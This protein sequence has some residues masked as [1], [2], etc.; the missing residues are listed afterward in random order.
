MP[1]EKI[2]SEIVK[3][4]A[5]R[6]KESQKR[7]QDVIDRW[8]K[9]E[10]VI[11]P[12]ILGATKFP[13]VPSVLQ[14]TTEGFDRLGELQ[15]QNKEDQ[16]FANTLSLE[17]INKYTPKF[18]PIAD[19]YGPKSSIFSERELADMSNQSE[20]EYRN[21]VGQFTNIFKSLEKPS[22]AENISSQDVYRLKDG[23]RELTDET[24]LDIAKAYKYAQRNG[25]NKPDMSQIAREVISNKLY[26]K[27][28]DVSNI[29]KLLNWDTQKN[30]SAFSHG[31]ENELSSMAKWSTYL[32]LLM[33]RGVQKAGKAVGS[34]G[35]EKFGE[36]E[37]N[38]YSKDAMRPFFGNAKRE[39]W[40]PTNTSDKILQGAGELVPNIIMMM[41]GN[42]LM[43]SESA[44]GA[45]ESKGAQ[46][47]AKSQLTKNFADAMR[48]ST[49]GASVNALKGVLY[50]NTGKVLNTVGKFLEKGSPYIGAYTENMVNQI[51]GFAPLMFDNY[52][53]QKIQEGYSASEAVD[54]ALKHTM[55]GLS[56]EAF[57]S[58][59]SPFKGVGER[60]L[61]KKAL[62]YTTGRNL[63]DYAAKV[64]KDILGEGLEE[65]SNTWADAAMDYNE[66][67]K[68]YKDGVEAYKLGLTQELPNK[69]NFDSQKVFAE[70]M[71]S[72]MIGGILG[73]IFG[74]ISNYSVINTPMQAQALSDGLKNKQGFFSRIDQMSSKGKITE[75]EANSLKG[76][77]NA[78]EPYVESAK[79]KNLEGVSAIQWGI[80]AARS[81]EA[82]NLL[83]S[84]EA[85]NM[86]EEEKVEIIN[87]GLASTNAM[88]Q[89]EDGKWLRNRAVDSNIMAEFANSTTPQGLF[90]QEQAND[91]IDKGMFE[92]GKIDLTN[93]D[94]ITPLNE[95][96]TRDTSIVDMAEA[97]KN[98]QMQFEDKFGM[99]PVLDE[100][101]KVIDGKKRIALALANGATELDVM[102]AMPLER[103]TELI[104]DAIENGVAVGLDESSLKGLSPQQQ[105]VVKQVAN[106]FVA[107]TQEDINNKTPEKI[108]Y[109]NKPVFWAINELKKAGF[110]DNQIAKSMSGILGKNVPE[111]V[112]KAFIKEN[113]TLFDKPVKVSAKTKEQNQKATSKPI[114]ET[115]EELRSLKEKMLRGGLSKQERTDT[116]NRIKELENSEKIST[117]TK[118][119][120]QL[121]DNNMAERLDKNCP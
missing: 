94:V 114:G 75:T 52:Y 84:K 25:I 53:K 72:A 23:K 47:V 88:K 6:Q 28:Y 102:K 5:Q 57:V 44:V 22:D 54:Q 45:L 14:S 17:A 82:A 62:G 100:N 35:I 87:K 112:L 107:L 64:G 30:S 121:I 1:L 15:V 3:G 69:P 63:K 27:A 4:S 73:G 32:S 93:P 65:F 7:T 26:S 119:I 70:S 68:Q 38:I 34:E 116:R 19:P 37:V 48:S 66:K 33:A 103:S 83:S 8:S 49:Q 43:A 41:A 51:P 58:P 60:Q 9:T 104:N 97:M 81:N 95:D 106:D 98:G 31:V 16:D 11:N 89:I 115:V 105:E 80:E 61:V 108:N 74:G 99:P 76:F 85:E 39:E 110:T 21:T 36:N 92:S 10:G 90:T 118:I 78:L 50:N 42:P 91:I 40:Q 86:T 46:L 18:N 24:K 113:E 67:L 29:E 12:T 56:I 101:G 109:Y 77:V 120:D 59:F 2:A 20:N 71:E 79:K 96:G 111:G 117:F 55:V 13:Q